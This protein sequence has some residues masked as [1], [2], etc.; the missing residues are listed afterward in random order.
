M[1]HTDN[2]QSREREVR[3][4]ELYARRLLYRPPPTWWNGTDDAWRE[5]VRANFED[6]LGAQRNI[7]CRPPNPLHPTPPRTVRKELWHKFT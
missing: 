6:V 1:S 3:E 4:L 5:C 2:E 7:E